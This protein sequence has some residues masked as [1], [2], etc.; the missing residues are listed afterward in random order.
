MVRFVMFFPLKLFFTNPSFRLL[1][2]QTHVHFL[3]Q[4]LI[5]S[6]SFTFRLPLPISKSR[7]ATI[8]VPC[9]VSH[10]QS[11]THSLSCSIAHARSVRLTFNFS[12][13][14]SHFWSY[15]PSSLIPNH[16]FIRTLTHLFHSHSMT[17]GFSPNFS[18]TSS[19]S[20]L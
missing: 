6:R 9:A 11:F 13:S 18:L 17:F 7:S 3:T 1:L 8:S 16:I 2:N 4:F 14:A 19:F 20:D 12:C 10:S 5:H 15:S